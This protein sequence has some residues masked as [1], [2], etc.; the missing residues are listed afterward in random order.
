MPMMSIEPRV[1]TYAPTDIDCGDALTLARPT[2][3]RIPYGDSPVLSI[4]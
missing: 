1:L 3:V 4:R 2:V